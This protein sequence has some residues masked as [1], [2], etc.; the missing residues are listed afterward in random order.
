MRLLGLK[1][2]VPNLKDSK[3]IKTFYKILFYFELGKGTT[4]RF[5]QFIP[6]VIIILGGL[7]FLLGVDVTPKFTIIFLFVVVFG[8]TGLGWILK[9]TG[10][11]DIDRYVQASKDPVQSEILEAARKINKF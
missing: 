4:A 11:Y 3:P 8:F 10:F 6:D 1:R 7:K 9:K 2:L 5:Y